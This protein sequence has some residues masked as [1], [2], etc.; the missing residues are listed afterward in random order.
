MHVSSTILQKKTQHLLIKA[1]G[2]YRVWHIVPILEVLPTAKQHMACHG[3][4]AGGKFAQLH[5]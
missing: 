1:L 3:P 2:E 5:Y 4:G